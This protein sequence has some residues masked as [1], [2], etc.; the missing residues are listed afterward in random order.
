ME[1]TPRV[2]VV[3]VTYNRPEHLSGTLAA[4][5]ASGWPFA[6]VVVVD[7]GMS[8]SARSVVTEWAERLPVE[9][10]Q[11]AE[12]LGPA[13]GAAFGFKLLLDRDVDYLTWSDDDDAWG[14]EGSFGDLMEIIQGDSS[15]GAVGR[16]GFYW[17]WHT[18]K[19][20]RIPDEDLD[21]P[22]PVGSLMGG[23]SV[24]TVRVDVVRK[25]G[26][27]RADL[28]WGF[29]DIEYALR[30][31]RAG[32]GLVVDGAALLDRRVAANRLGDVGRS[33]QPRCVM[34]M[35]EFYDNRNYIA[36]MRTEYKRYD[37]IL[38]RIAEVIV[39]SGTESVRHPRSGLPYAALQARAIVDGIAGRLGRREPPGSRR[40]A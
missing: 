23:G 2:G 15:I 36:V 4:I 33:S 37:L 19:L 1:H 22:T 3:V 18:G 39:K 14:G 30:I 5:H 35:R 21:G 34:G 17:D 12:N 31:A 7:N 8:P 9:H 38:R 6:S 27:P 16:T 28:F 40:S 26:L 11:M 25:I 10:H 13:G 29:E 24:M 20:K 32:Y